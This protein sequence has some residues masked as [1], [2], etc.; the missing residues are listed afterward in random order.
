MDMQR[1]CFALVLGVV[2]VWQG[3]IADEIQLDGKRLVDVYIRE[4][5]ELYYIEIP[6]SGEVKCVRKAN[7]GPGQVEISSD[8]DARAELHRQ[9][10]A[11]QSTAIQS[12]AT[13][14]NPRVE[15]FDLD[16][17]PPIP[18]G[19]DQ[20]GDEMRDS[21][22]GIQERSIEVNRAGERSLTL[23]GSDYY[24][25]V[26]RAEQEAAE[27]ERHTQRSEERA[28]EAAA[29]ADFAEQRKRQ[30]AI[31]SQNRQA[32]IQKEYASDQRNGAP[33]PASNVDIYDRFRSIPSQTN[34]NGVVQ[35]YPSS[36]HRTVGA[37]TYS[38]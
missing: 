16:Q 8:A 17:V 22:R 10:K 7:V 25:P 13:K 32:A 3:V 6:G 24:D 14:R 36:L 29:Q 18:E 27:I 2:L 38:R 20:R 23:R 37:I 1:G 5:P 35:N 15:M 33:L 26:A 12:P 28:A 9:W 31:D 34:R 19:S 21:L 4:S 30:M 11:K